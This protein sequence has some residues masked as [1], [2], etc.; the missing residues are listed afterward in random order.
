MNEDETAPLLSKKKKKYQRFTL[1]LVD[2]LNSSMNTAGIMVLFY[3]LFFPKNFST[4][5]CPDSMDHFYEDTG[6]WMF[7]VVTVTTMISVPT[8]KHVLQKTLKERAPSDQKYYLWYDEKRDSFETI[9]FVFERF[10]PIICEN[11][12]HYFVFLAD[13]MFDM[14]F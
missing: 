14:E 9:A 6:K 8:I 10:S 5:R 7:I 3:Q 4:Y 12:S 13:G 2:N 1:K 11:T